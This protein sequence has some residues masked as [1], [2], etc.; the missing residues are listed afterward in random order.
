MRMGVFSTPFGH[1]SVPHAEMRPH[2]AANVERMFLRECYGVELERGRQSGW[3]WSGDPMWRIS[4]LTETF[5][6]MYGYVHAIDPNPLNE[7][8]VI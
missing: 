3:G 5:A 1:E 7:N 4:M 2:A 8:V 6:R